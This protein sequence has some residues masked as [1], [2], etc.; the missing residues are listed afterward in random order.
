[1][2]NARILLT[3][4]F[5]YLTAAQPLLADPITINFGGV[6]TEQ[7]F[8]PGQ[9]WPI[10]T[11]VTGSFTYDPT[12][13]A[14]PFFKGRIPAVASGS[15]GSGASAVQFGPSAFLSFINDSDFYFGRG[16]RGSVG[17]G[18]HV[19]L[20]VY[21]VPFPFNPPTCG[22]QPPLCLSEGYIEVQLAF[23]PTGTLISDITAP[24]L[25]PL[26]L[27]IGNSLGLFFPV[28]SQLA[29]IMGEVTKAE[30]AAVPEPGVLSLACVA[31]VMAYGCARRRGQ[32]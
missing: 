18:D 22:V 26:P 16:N 3:L 28:R 7:F 19:V 15:I 23:D 11:A 21:G 29:D 1:M 32:H 12:A 14:D 6:L 10:G 27:E 25:D 5:L 31:V 4:A 13:P 20:T 8:P 2:A 17:F 24:P 30:P 9:S